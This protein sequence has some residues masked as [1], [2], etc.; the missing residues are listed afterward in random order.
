[1]RIF[2]IWWTE[3]GA[4]CCP[5][6]VECHSP[7]KHPL[8]KRGVLDA[9]DDA[10]QI[11]AWRQEYPKAN[12]GNATG[13]GLLTVDLD[14]RPGK[15]GLETFKALG[16]APRTYTV[17][18]GSGGLHLY[19]R[20]PV[21]LPNTS[22][23]LGLGID[24]RGENGYVLAPG[25]GHV[26]GGTYSVV[27]D[28]PIADIPGWL[29]ER[30][31][32]SQAPAAATERPAFPAASQAVLDAA[33]TALDHHGPAIQ[34]DA[35]DLHTYRAAAILTHDFA[36]T[37]DEAFPIFQRW[38][39]DNQPPWSDSDLH[40]KLRGGLKYGT[41]AYGSRRSGDVVDTARRWILDWQTAPGDPLVIVNKIKTLRFTDTTARSVVEDL[42]TAATG[43]KRRALDL[44]KV[45][46]PT[47]EAAEPGQVRISYDLDRMADEAIA[48]IAPHIFQRNGVLIEVIK[49]RRTFISELKVPRVRDLMSKY[50]KFIKPD[51][52]G[53]A[54]LSA[55]P[56]E[57]AEILHARR[58][59]PVRELEAVSTAPI[60]L[61]D[62]SILQDRGY[63][64][65]ARVF[66]EPNISV[67]VP[68]SPDLE[69]AQ[70]AVR[71]FKDL[72]GDFH[73]F[74]PEDLSAWVAALLSPL[75][76]AATDNAPSPLFVVSASSPGAGKTLLTD[77]I[78]RIVTGSSAEIRPYN[79]RDSGEW[80]KRLTSFV[81]AASPISVFDNVNG[82]L[83]DEALDRLITSSTWSD[84]LLG[85]S[86]APPLPNVTTW[87][88]T[89][90]NT[91][92]VNDTIR[93]CLMI[94]IVVDTEKPQE[95]N[96]FKRPSLADYV[97]EK[98]GML[99][100]Q[101]L[102]ILRAYHCAG[103]PDQKLA[104]WG[105]FG[106]WSAL[107]R[108]A[109]VWAGLPDPYLTQQ[110]ISADLNEPMAEVHDFWLTTVDD[111]N[112]T[113][114]DITRLANDRGVEELVGTREMLLPRQLRKLLNPFIDKPRNNKR[115]RRD[116]G[117]YM[118]ECF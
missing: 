92:P 113:A 46:K 98:R 28:V 66:L 97:M 68:D 4:C 72:V 26:S 106:A 24:T 20:T 7:G 41:G 112:G 61:A 58:E 53:S 94:R 77:L 42:L 80:S 71:V 95:R 54:T 31:K 64:E 75:T 78:A 22:G 33:Q 90:N 49:G 44:P 40:A 19:F 57:I 84:R 69:N 108:G 15:N 55:P 17:R 81:K 16:Q 102:T 117:R 91:E 115:I 51:A 110:R 3:D 100:T 93:R 109:L 70:H 11:A 8:T 48:E 114:S 85:A 1:M 104:P 12:W 86:D 107:V 38:N 43:I 18:T 45:L 56:H 60:F 13:D 47:A 32:P 88:S 59:H 116:G 25:S 99:L 83:G 29:L 30:L 9:S 5:A 105:S 101:A 63:S 35:G 36:L 39:Q 74:A 62:G 65:N 21:R 79:T 111:S 27:L 73:F 103:R 76:K 23:K 34:G 67:D 89:G 14:I 10:E 6:G 2:P 50:S 87:M 118:V 96:D 52:E 82:Q 37:E